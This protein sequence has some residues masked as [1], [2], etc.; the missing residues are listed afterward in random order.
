MSHINHLSKGFYADPI[1]WGSCA[2]DFMLA[3]SMTYPD[4]PDEDT[5]LRYKN[6]YY[7]LT[8]VLPCVV[9]RDHYKQNISKV[10]PIDNYLGNSK[11][12]SKWVIQMHNIVNRKNNKK[13]VGYDEALK[14]YFE[15][16]KHK[17]GLDVKFKINYWILSIILI[18]LTLITGYFYQNHL[19]HYLWG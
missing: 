15:R 2:W 18:I 12:L 16:N 5:A 8:D 13:V 6:F 9:C 14:L 7:S 17:A 3:I 11:L 1:I 10:L 4:N 19:N